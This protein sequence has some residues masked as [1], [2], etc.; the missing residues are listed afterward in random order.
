M[1]RLSWAVIVDMPGQFNVEDK[2]VT[3]THYSFNF[4]YRIDK[5]SCLHAFYSL[6]IS[7][8]TVFGFN[9]CTLKFFFP[10]SVWLP[11]ILWLWWLFSLC[12]F[13]GHCC[14]V[15]FDFHTKI[16]LYRYIFVNINIRFDVPADKKTRLN[17]CI[18]Y[19][20]KLAHI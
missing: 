6:L 4:Y 12:I 9:Y 13:N 20:N 19:G 17:Y 1:H 16:F 11:E 8:K 14:S 7:G 3:G 15:I 2:W 18:Q 10:I 5:W